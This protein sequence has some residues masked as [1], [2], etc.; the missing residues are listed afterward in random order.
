[1]FLLDKI[2]YDLRPPERERAFLAS[3]LEADK[4]KMKRVYLLALCIIPTFLFAAIIVRPPSPELTLLTAFR[5]LGI[6]VVLA[7]LLALRKTEH[8]KAFEWTA[9]ACLA[10]L[11]VQI[12]I[13]KSLTLAQSE[14]VLAWT[15]FVVFLIYLTVPIG[16]RFRLSCA[17]FLSVVS[18]IV[19]SY[20]HDGSHE[21][22][23][24]IGLVGVYL[25]SNIFGSICALNAA[26]TEREEF[27]HLE[28]EKALKSKLELAL[29]SLE[30]SVESRNQ[31]YRVLAH[32]LRSGI[33][34]MG[35]IG[36]LLAEGDHHSEQERQ[37]M[38]KMICA[39]SKSSYELLDNL[40]QWAISQTESID[41][42]LNDIPLNHAVAKCVGLLTV[43]AREK[44]IDLNLEID[45]AIA[46]RADSRMLETV[47]RNL[48]SNAIKFTPS[49]GVVQVTAK[50]GAEG[51]VVISITDNGVGIDAE[52]LSRIFN[53]KHDENSYGTGGESGTNLGL[54]ICLEFVRKLG[55]EIWVSSEVSKGTQFSF[56]VPK[57]N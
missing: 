33:S 49:K 14:T 19:W 17:T 18:I 10:W 39:S 53:L 1:M 36:E 35:S 21:L 46:V 3:R 30:E 26:R 22:L 8:R 24:G 42:H 25:A 51:F 56:S 13:V 11:A 12:G 50:E 31:I 54:R 15:V 43:L 6:L 48:A 23:N 20:K 40:L 5:G 9:F 7:G 16:L 27:L 41:P 28:S 32:D 38:V 55:G 29:T 45:P 37:E 44:E 47:I 4:L 34:A 57:V 2:R 52:R